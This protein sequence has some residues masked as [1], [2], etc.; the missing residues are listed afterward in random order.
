M[1]LNKWNKMWKRGQE[2]PCVDLCKDSSGGGVYLGTS[3]KKWF[4]QVL[5]E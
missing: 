1:E 4:A 5:E 2:S 3:G